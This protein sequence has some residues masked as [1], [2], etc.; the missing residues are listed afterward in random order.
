MV[1]KMCNG[2]LTAHRLLIHLESCVEGGAN[3]FFFCLYAWFIH[4]APGVHA[5]HSGAGGPGCQSLKAYVFAHSGTQGEGNSTHGY[6]DLMYTKMYFFHSSVF[7]KQ[8][9]CVTVGT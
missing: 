1:L 5:S 2:S 8:Q 4:L 9:V 3:T 7:I 6:A